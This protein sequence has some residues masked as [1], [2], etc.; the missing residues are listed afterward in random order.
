MHPTVTMICEKLM[1]DPESCLD[2]MLLNPWTRAARLVI[3]NDDALFDEDEVQAVVNAWREAKR[4]HFF[5]IVVECIE[6]PKAINNLPYTR[7]Q[8]E[9]KR[10]RDEEQYKY[11]EMERMMQQADKRNRALQSMPQTFL[12]APSGRY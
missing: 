12:T 4:K 8:K 6:N 7:E 5:G 3:E 9:Q 1:A 2:G 11:E 10:K